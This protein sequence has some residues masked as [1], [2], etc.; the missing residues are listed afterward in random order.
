MREHLA[1]EQAQS[2]LLC[3]LEG[4]LLGIEALAVRELLPLPWITPVREAPP[5]VAGVVNVR[6]V[7]IPVVDLSAAL[8]LPSQQAQPT[9]VLVLLQ[10]GGAT[11]GIVVSEVRDV[12]PLGASHAQLDSAPTL[13]G[14]S[15][16]VSGLTPVGDEIVQ[17]VRLDTLF[18]WGAA[19][20]LEALDI[21]RTE[22]SR[23]DVAP[24]LFALASPAYI[25]IFRARARSLS[26][27]FEVALETENQ[28][29]HPLAAFALDGEYFGLDLSVVREF[30]LLR[31]VTP[32]PWCPPHIVGL[33]N[34][35]GET[36]TL[37]DISGALGLSPIS[38]KSASSR[39]IVVQCEG[40]RVGIVVD[41]VLDIISVDAAQV[42][43]GTQTMVKNEEAV[44]GVVRGTLFFQEKML[45]VIDLPRLLQ[46][47]ALA[48]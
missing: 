42:T 2:H 18:K 44:M 12:R 3:L 41:E 15:T 39:V 9:D 28:Q 31:T 23:A 24:S 10:R 26:Q 21:A 4:T 48:A 16:L 46:S 20:D 37:I 40:L 8:G 17:I 13:R 29:L 7:L 33:M 30:S 27:N 19:S 32:I 5:L 22:V 1:L 34:L 11:V 6:G 36:L 45:G 38:T 43:L 25:E 14:G 47:E 35:R